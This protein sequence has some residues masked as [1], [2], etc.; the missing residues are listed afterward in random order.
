MRRLPSKSVRSGRNAENVAYSD[1]RYVR[2]GRCNHVVHLDR[3]SR[4]PYGSRAG[5]G[6]T[7]PDKVTYD[8]SAITYN[9]KGYTYDG[10]HV[11]FTITG[12]CPFCGAYTFDKEE[13]RSKS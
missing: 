8:D 11:D 1:D 13:K 12:G 2:C 7:H 4:A 10:H 5:Q 6:V 9:N 3:H